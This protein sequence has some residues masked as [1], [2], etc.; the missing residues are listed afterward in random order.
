[1]HGIDGCL[2]LVWPRLIAPQASVSVDET[3][4]FGML[5]ILL[6]NSSVP[7]DGQA[8]ANPW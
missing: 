3:T 1:V 2:D 8:C 4:Y 5:F 7:I 6:P